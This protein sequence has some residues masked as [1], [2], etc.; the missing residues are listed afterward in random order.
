MKHFLFPCNKTKYVSPTI[1]HMKNIFKCF[2]KKSSVIIFNC[3]DEKRE[4]K[5]IEKYKKIYVYN[6]ALEKFI[7]V[8]FIYLNFDMSEFTCGRYIDTWHNG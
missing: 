2:K 6:N 3:V 7:Q 8:S 5:K 1:L 4:N